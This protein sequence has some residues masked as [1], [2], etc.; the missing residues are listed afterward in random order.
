MWLF[1]LSVALHLES[2]GHY[3]IFF[4]SEVL[5]IISVLFKDLSDMLGY[6]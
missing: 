5:H 4:L 6:C 3:V 1:V 2:H